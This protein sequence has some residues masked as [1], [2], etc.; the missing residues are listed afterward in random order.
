[1]ESKHTTAG[2]SFIKPIGTSIGNVGLST[3]YDLRFPEQSLLLRKMGAD[4]L[5]YP[6]AFTVPTGTMH[7]KALLTARAIETQC[8]VIA[9]AQHGKHNQKR[10]SYGHS[11]VV[12]PNGKILLDAPNETRVDV[13]DLDFD[14][15]ETIRTNMP[16]F[17]HRRD[18][19]YRLELV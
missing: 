2:K 4:I 15:L 8:F 11:L 13:V 5:T 1:M 9:A 19:I 18:D 6:S 7:W 10:E 3:C 12:D 16:V 14:V 17:Q